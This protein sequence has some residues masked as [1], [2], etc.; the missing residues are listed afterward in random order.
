MRLK[1]SVQG[2]ILIV[3]GIFTWRSARGA[4][5]FLLIMG[6][7]MLLLR[8]EKYIYKLCLAFVRQYRRKNI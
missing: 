7:T 3:L 4:A 5:F 8:T 2:L 1:D 6:A